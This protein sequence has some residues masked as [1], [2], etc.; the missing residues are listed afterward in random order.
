MECYGLN[1]DGHQVSCTHSQRFGKEIGLAVTSW[2][3]IGKGW[4]VRAWP[5]RVYLPSGSLAARRLTLSCS[6]SM[7]SSLELA[8]NGLKTLAKIKLSYFHCVSIL[9][10]QQKHD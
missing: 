7:Q 5:G 1:L 6:S 3:L 4:S 9:F 8:D 10:Q 2:S